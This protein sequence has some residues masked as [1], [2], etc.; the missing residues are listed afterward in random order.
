MTDTRTTPRGRER[1]APRIDPTYGNRKTRRAR[2]Q[3]EAAARQAAHD[4]MRK[5]DKS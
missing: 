5:K 1:T 4:V 2:R 3:R